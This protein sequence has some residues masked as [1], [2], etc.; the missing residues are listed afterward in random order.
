MRNILIFI[1]L[2]SAVL[3]SQ[4]KT[5]IEK[6]SAQTGTAMIMGYNDYEK[7]K[8]SPDNQY[9]KAGIKFQTRVIGTPNRPESTKG[10]K[11]DVYDSSGNNGSSFIDE[12][13]IGDLISGLE[14]LTRVDSDVTALKSFE[15]SYKTLGGFKATVYN[16]NSGELRLALRAGSRT[17]Y[18]NDVGFI[19]TLIEQIKQASP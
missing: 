14:Y 6:F 7:I 18:V 19:E 1:L 3:F 11:V 17:A 8:T 10:I 5:D 15:V 4:E 13:E 9:S 16:N 2:F 12:S